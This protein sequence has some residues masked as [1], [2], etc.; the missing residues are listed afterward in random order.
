[1]QPK[2]E[3]EVGMRQLPI[4]EGVEVVFWV[5]LSK[6][7]DRFLRFI[8]GDWERGVLYKC[9]YVGDDVCRWWASPTWLSV[10]GLDDC[11]DCEAD[12]GI[13]EIRWMRLNQPKWRHRSISEALR[14]SM[15]WTMTTRIK[16]DFWFGYWLDHPRSYRRLGES[17][18]IPK[19]RAEMTDQQSGETVLDLCGC[20]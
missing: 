7:G 11:D 6:H 19:W 12:Y 8:K 10:D 2:I 3:M 4:I 1:M 15:T 18:S 5:R 20:G 9:I 13:T 14:F 16:P 17:S